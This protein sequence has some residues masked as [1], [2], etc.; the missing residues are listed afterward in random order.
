MRSDKSSFVN[1]ER[2]WRESPTSA[3][4]RRLKMIET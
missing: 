4:A 3:A 2:R 1:V